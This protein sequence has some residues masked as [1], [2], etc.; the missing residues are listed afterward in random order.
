MRDE[1]KVESL[2]KRLQVGEEAHLSWLNLAGDFRR[3]F[4][5]R[6]LFPQRISMSLN[7]RVVRGAG[8]RVLAE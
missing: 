3:L 5:M 1:V 4:R 7:R 8:P 2:H 6:K